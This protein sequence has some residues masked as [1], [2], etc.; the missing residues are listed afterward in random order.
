MHQLCELD[1]DVVGDLGHSVVQREN[2]VDSSHAAQERNQLRLHPEDHFRGNLAQAGQETRVLHG[3]AETMIAA[4]EHAPAFERAT[5]PY[6]LQMP[7]PCATVDSTPLALHLVA[8]LPGFLEA[9]AAHVREPGIRKVYDH[10]QRSQRAFPSMRRLPESTL[11][12]LE[13]AAAELAWLA[14]SRIVTPVQTLNVQF[15]STSAGAARNA[16]PVCDI[17]RDVETQLRGAIA[18]RFPAHGIVGEEGADSRPEAD[19]VWVIDPLDGTTNFLNGL[20]LYAA[21]IGVLFDRVPVAGA[22]WC[23]TTHARGAG[24]YHAHE[25]G[26]LHLDG[27]AVVRRAPATWRGLAGEP[28]SAPRFGARF[29]TRVLACA[30]LECAFVAAGILQLAYLPSP[31]AWDVAAGIVLARS[32]DCYVATRRRDTW[33][34]FESFA[35]GGELRNWREP[36]LIGKER[37]P[38]HD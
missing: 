30:A 9:T 34:T 14:G 18:E 23:A 11:I 4:H 12:D 16:S 2:T 7:R 38:E 35:A 26:R 33:H 28:G 1:V 22:V 13:K 24:V 20:P 19:F 37:V 3:V 15:K 5:I 17:D 25:S 29:D 6:G 27:V 21:S 8:H 10:A 32:A 31:A 36:V